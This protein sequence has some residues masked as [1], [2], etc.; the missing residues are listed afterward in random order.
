[1]LGLR[2]LSNSIAYVAS[3][4]AVVG[5][6]KTA[7]VEF[8]KMNIRVNAVCPVF[9]RSPLFDQMFDIDPSF[10]EKLK[11]NIPLRRYGQPIDIANA[12]M[13]LCS[14]SSS[15]ITGLALP[16]DGGMMA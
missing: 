12:I 13:W 3:K 14:D 5:M 9:T 7:A 16:V 11:R 15:F 4:H 8:A 2:H 10:E 1:M 6:T